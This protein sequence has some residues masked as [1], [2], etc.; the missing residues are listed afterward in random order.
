LFCHKLIFIFILL[1]SEAKKVTKNAFLS[2]GVSFGTLDFIAACFCSYAHAE[3]S[4]TAT[5][6]KTSLTLHESCV[7]RN[8]IFYE[9]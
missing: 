5:S 9:K 7:L 2:L 4:R 6:L 1:F 3:P 8:E